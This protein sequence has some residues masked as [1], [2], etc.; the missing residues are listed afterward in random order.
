[1]PD[2]WAFEKPRKPSLPEVRNTAWARNEIDRFVLA[3]LEAK[4][5]TPSPD[6]AP[7]VLRTLGNAT[8]VM[9]NSVLDAAAQSGRYIYRGASDGMYALGQSWRRF[10]K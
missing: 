2:W 8:R 10:R 5:L 1:M 7:R 6:A 4:Q 3:K 9:R